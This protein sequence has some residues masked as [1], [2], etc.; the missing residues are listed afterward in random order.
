MLKETS[1]YAESWNVAWRKKGVGSILE[2]KKTEFNVIDN[3]FRY[4]AADPFIFE[5]AGKTYI[6]AEL[7]DYVKCRGCIGYYELSSSSPKWKKIIEEEYH[8]SYPYIFETKEGIFIMPESGANKDLTVYRAVS[9]P[10]KWEKISVLRS[11]IQY[12][13]TTPF[14]WNNHKYALAYDVETAEYKLILL[15]LESG[16]KADREISCSD[17]N[18]RRPAGTVFLSEDKWMRPAQNCAGGYGKGLCFYSFNMNDRG[19]YFEKLQEMISPEKLNYSKK[20]YLDGMHTYNA[21]KEYEVIDIKTRRF[22]LLNFI[23]RL[24]G[25]VRKKG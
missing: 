8:L 20:I 24:I 21:S 17:I 9:F 25:K 5:Y 6:F 1:L 11:G 13:D 15:D 2:D 4:W 18:C 14:E 23:F 10:D 3:S 16:E 12:G 19:E 22:N 7:Y